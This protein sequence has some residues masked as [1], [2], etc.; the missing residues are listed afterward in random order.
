MKRDY[1]L[2]SAIFSA[3]IILLVSCA[4]TTQLV[5]IPD[6]TKPIEKPENCRIYVMR[7]TTFAYAISMRVTDNDTPIGN[8]GPKGYL[9]WE[10]SA[11][12]NTINGI[13]ENIS[14]LPMVTEA[15]QTYYIQQN[16]RMGFLFA[17]N[18][19]EA[20][21]EATGKQMLSKCKPPVKK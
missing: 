14:T 15:G 5:E 18:K 11:G 17:R 6:Q 13:S 4:T 8:T 20:V 3:G 16:V 7:P 19:L 10:T 12:T 1:L 2:K 9:C 21:D